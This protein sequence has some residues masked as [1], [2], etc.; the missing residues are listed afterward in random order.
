[1][2]GLLAL[3]GLT[4]VACGDASNP[5]PSRY[6]NFSSSGSSGDEGPGTS[7][8][9]SGGSSGGSTSSGSTTSS[10]SSSGT[11]STEKFSVDVAADTQTAELYESKTFSVTLSSKNGFA[12]DVNLTLEGAP[13]E[14]KASLDKTT[15][16]VTAAAGG[17]ALLT[18]SSRKGGANAVT[19]KASAI[20]STV[21]SKVVTLNTDKVLT[22]RLRNGMGADLNNPGNWQSLDGSVTNSQFIVT[23]SLPL[24]VKFVNQDTVGHI[25]HRNDQGG[26]THGDQANPL[27]PNATEAP[28]TLNAAYTGSFY[29]HTAGAGTANGMLNAK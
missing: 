20:G 6:G 24:T 12:G 1:M 21:A 16:A 19:I 18:V 13:A 26:F 5:N 25:V 14:A 17:T 11:V 3:A 29:E 10:T 9:S 15:V 23:N 2:L 22:I 28:R 27:A 7:T 4:A 8:S